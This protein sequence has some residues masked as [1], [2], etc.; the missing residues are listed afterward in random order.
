MRGLRSSE[1]VVSLALLAS[2]VGHFAIQTRFERRHRTQQLAQSG[3]SSIAPAL[4]PVLESTE[5]GGLPRP[6]PFEELKPE[7]RIVPA[8]DIQGGESRAG[9]PQSDGRPSEVP[10]PTDAEPSKTSPDGDSAT[11]HGESSAVRTVIE[12]ELATASREEREIWY[13]ELK[14]VPPDVVRDLL[15]VRKQLRALPQLLGGM[16][17]RLASVDPTITVSPREIPAEP[18]S[19]KIRFS[20]P[21]HQLAAAMLETAISQS[22]HNLMNSLTP[23]F[24]R[25]RVTLV[26]SYSSG[27][28][29][30]TATPL[31]PDGKLQGEGCRMAPL[32]LDL[33][34]GPLK[35]TNRQHD[36]AIDGEGFF[37]VRQ[38]ES[39]YL[40]R[41]GAF[42]VDHER[43]LVLAVAQE[44]AVLQPPI[45]IPD[46]TRE[47]QIS[48]NGAV[49]VLKADESDLT[50]IG[51]L[52]LGRVASP[53]RLKPV[54]QTLF[55]STEASGGIAIGMPMSG[56]FG[57]IQ[58]GCLE[59]S[60]V[61][62]ERELDEIDAM[63]QILKAIPLQS[64]RPAT[65]RS[66][67]PAPQ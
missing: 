55:V 25:L 60:N 30:P 49:T 17:E 2:L 53:A 27:R 14:S 54:G 20:A 61:D 45:Q 33:A 28:L 12:E 50:L 21:D 16:P 10:T 65:A 46:D 37:V 57:E 4:F 40:T 47:I 64:S 67:V 29:E 62:L 66:P 13:D 41:C 35:K 6:F 7:G 26:D 34:Q 59:L 18:A 8:L 31:N 48:A 39:E 15:K 5:I 3:S 56:G 42:T 43:Q 11:D 23:G 52:Q 38:G 19:Q 63:S 1:F 22:R 36:L 9:S 51:Q 44:S 32:V 24:K 58:Q